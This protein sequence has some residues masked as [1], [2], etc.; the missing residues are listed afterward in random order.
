MTALKITS[1]TEKER[2]DIKYPGTLAKV[3]NIRQLIQLGWLS[4][5]QGRGITRPGGTY[6]FRPVPEQPSRKLCEV[7]TVPQQAGHRQCPHRETSQN[8]DLPHATP[9]LKFCL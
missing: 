6:I 2:C 3:V 7:I 1:L 9:K 5:K 8:S 4:L